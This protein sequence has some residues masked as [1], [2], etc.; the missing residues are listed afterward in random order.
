MDIEA[1][2]IFIQILEAV[3]YLH[4]EGI[5]HRDLKFT[6]ILIDE[7]R[8]VKLIDFGFACPAGQVT[9]EF[10]GTPAYMSPEIIQKKDYRGTWVDV[11]AL[12]VILHKILTG[13]YAFGSSYSVM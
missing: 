9:K 8:R 12:G 2:H 13:E 5:A 1:Q 11:W 6:N 10:C 3:A 4:N 7:E